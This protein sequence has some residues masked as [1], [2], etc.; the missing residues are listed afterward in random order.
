M[1]T[2]RDIVFMLR[3]IQ[4]DEDMQS[5]YKTGGVNPIRRI[6]NDISINMILRGL[7]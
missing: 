2:A 7:Y 5:I 1:I 3:I 6:M 4:F